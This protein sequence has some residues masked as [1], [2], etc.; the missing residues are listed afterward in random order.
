M[1]TIKL[2]NGVVMPKLIQGFSL[3]DGSENLTQNELGKIISCSI[4]YGLRA[5]DTAHDYGKSE[6]CVGNILKK[7]V[8][9]EIV[10]R[11]EIFIVTK[12]G[13]GQQYQGDI[14]NCVNK[15]LSALQ[16]DY[17]DLMLLHWPVPG[18]YIENWKKLEKVYESGKVKAIGIANTQIR[19][20]EALF[21]S[22][23]KYKPH[24]VQTEIHPFNTCDNMVAYCKDN[25]IIL[26]A[27][28][29][30]CKMMP[31]VKENRVLQSLA[32]KY[33]RSIAQIILRWHIDH[34]IAP[35]F[36][37][38]SEKHIKEMLDKIDKFE[39]TADDMALISILNINYRYNPESLN[40]PGF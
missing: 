32:I 31:M 2:Y 27:C 13:N 28:T 7:I 11:N 4:K 9:K 38:Y 6:R 37:S 26:Q 23:I 5:F 30:L 33:N 18:Y 34:N 8:K 10:N 17:I 1:E 20:L 21:N 15:S 12:I 16:T 22:D 29:A 36:R 14:N 25:N 35:I 24:V 19:H 40:C 3:I 39:I